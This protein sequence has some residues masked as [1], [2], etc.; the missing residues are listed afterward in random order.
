MN[1]RD[2]PARRDPDLLLTSQSWPYWKRSYEKRRRWYSIQ[3]QTL[4][5]GGRSRLSLCSN[6]SILSMS[7]EE[8]LKPTLACYN[9]TSYI[10]LDDGW[11]L[12]DGTVLSLSYI[13]ASLFQRLLSRWHFALKRISDTSQIPL[14]ALATATDE[15]FC[16]YT[17][18]PVGPSLK[19]G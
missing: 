18:E 17:G 13:N 19:P 2:G 14:H 7:I 11:N 3:S 15:K 10:Q 6:P 1:A 9:R 5:T 8:N 12:V 4:E 16:A